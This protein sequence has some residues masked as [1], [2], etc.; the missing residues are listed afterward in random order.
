MRYGS[1]AVYA[2]QDDRR[3]DPPPTR[4]QGP[5]AHMRYGSFAVYAAQD[6]WR[7]DTRST[8]CHPEPAQRGEGSVS[9]LR[10]RG[11][12][13]PMKTLVIGAGKSGVAAANFLAARGDE[14]VLTDKNE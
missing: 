10:Y 1:F 11:A 13:P 5:V 12:N 3:G 7:G 8:R 4:C 14:V 6:D 2:A 9:H